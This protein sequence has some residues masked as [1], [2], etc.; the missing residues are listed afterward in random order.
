MV[1]T[2]EQVPDVVR[3]QH[4]QEIAEFLGQ[5]VQRAKETFL[6]Y[7][8]LLGP[9][10]YH[11]HRD[12]EEPETAQPVRPEELTVDRALLFDAVEGVLIEIE[13][14]AAAGEEISDQAEVRAIVAAVV[15]VIDTARAGA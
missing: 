8:R 12:G 4:W 14:R 1:K 6:L 2:R 3:A 13:E 5:P 7:L 11:L 9:L 10:G 15:K